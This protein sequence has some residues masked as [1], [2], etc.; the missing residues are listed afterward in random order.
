[1]IAGDA[2]LEVA[3]A[4]PKRPMQMNFGLWVA[5]ARA[6]P[7]GNCLGEH[8]QARLGDTAGGAPEA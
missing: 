4:A 2:G 5:L 3:R 6:A 7:E 1:M 8:T